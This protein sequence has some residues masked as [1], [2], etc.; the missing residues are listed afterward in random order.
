LYRLAVGSRQ[1]DVDP[2]KVDKNNIG[3]RVSH[4]GRTQ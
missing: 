1:P 4:V 2:K 3:S